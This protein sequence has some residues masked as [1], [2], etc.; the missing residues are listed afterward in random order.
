MRIAHRWDA[1]Q[2]ET[3]AV[4][5]ARCTGRKY[6]PAVLANG[7]TPKQLLARSRYQLFKPADKWTESQR[8]RAEVLFEIYP[9]I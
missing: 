9:D 4:E 2:A 6:T 3:D 8:Q 1:I 5:E 7:D